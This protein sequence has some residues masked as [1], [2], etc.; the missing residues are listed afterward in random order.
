MLFGVEIHAGGWQLPLDLP[1][2]ELKLPRL[3]HEPA[4]LKG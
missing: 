3:N 4:V 2:R 1:V